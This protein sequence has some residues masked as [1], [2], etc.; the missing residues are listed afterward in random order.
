MT[1]GSVQVYIIPLRATGEAGRALP[2]RPV[3]T[4]RVIPAFSHGSDNGRQW[5]F[6][7]TASS[8]EGAELKLLRQGATVPLKRRFLQD[9]GLDTWEEEGYEGSLL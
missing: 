6:R 4:N 9:A 7:I 1:R 2:L 8:P 3:E 5:R